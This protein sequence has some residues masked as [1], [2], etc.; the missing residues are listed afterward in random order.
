MDKDK[1]VHQLFIGKVSDVIGNEKTRTLL[2]EA[3]EAFDIPVV[4]QQSELLIAFKNWDEKNK[5]TCFG[6]GYKDENKY[7][8]MAFLKSINCA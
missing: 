3:K 1:L 6:N 7:R 5:H 4:M 2:K 8:V